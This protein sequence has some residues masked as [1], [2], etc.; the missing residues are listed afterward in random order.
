MEKESARREESLNVRKISKTIYN[1]L[2]KLLHPDLEQ[3]ET[4]KAEKT[5]AM[6][7][8]NEAWQNNDFF[9]LLT[10]QSAYLQKHGDHIA[11]LPDKQ[12]NYYISVLKDQKTEL[13]QEL[14]MLERAPGIS[15]YIYRK[16]VGASEYITNILRERA[17]SEEKNDLVDRQ[18]NL[19]LSLSP[20]TFK[21]SLKK[22]K[23][24]EQ[25]FS[26]LDMISVITAMENATQRKSKNDW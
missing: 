2:V 11:Q 16:L 26:F 19:L 14:G 13:E 18:H 10:L 12:F 22:Y 20:E 23:I 25:D 1:E 3:D 15:G 5:E 21:P 4:R 8:V 6:K 7:K 9:G 24:Q 17:V